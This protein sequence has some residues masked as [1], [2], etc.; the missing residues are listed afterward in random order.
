[1]GSFQSLYLVILV[2]LNGNRTDIGLQNDWD[3]K[4]VFLKL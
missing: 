4:P 3:W 2:I 1:M